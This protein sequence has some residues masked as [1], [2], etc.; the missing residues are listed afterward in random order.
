MDDTDCLLN[1]RQGGLSDLSKKKILLSLLLLSVLSNLIKIDI[2][3][4][5]SRLIKLGEKWEVED[6][7]L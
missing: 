3:G 6:F 1:I 2:Q 5:I 7:W 4:Y